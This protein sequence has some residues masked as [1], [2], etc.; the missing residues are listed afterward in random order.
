MAD[1]N[2]QL[3][4]FYRRYK[5]RDEDFEGFQDGMVDHSRGMFEGLL[6]GSVLAGLEPDPT[7][8]MFVSVSEGIA[9]GPSGYLHVVNQ[10]TLEFDTPAT[11]VRMDLVVVRPKLEENA[12]ITN[13]TNPFQQVPLRTLQGSEVLILQGDESET[14]EYPAKA[15]NDVALFGVRVE[16]AQTTLAADDLDFEARDLIGKNS[17]FQQDAAKYDDRLRPYRST[18]N[19]LGVKPSQLQPPFARVFSYVNR[20]APS[21][22][23]KDAIGNYNPE[24]TFLNF[25][26]GVITGGDESSANF[27]PTIP[28]AGN[29]IVASVG[30]D[31]DDE[32]QVR[33]GTEGTRAQCLSGVV[34]QVA[35]GAGSVLIANNVKLVAF[36]ILGSADGAAITELGFFDSRGVFGIGNDISGIQTWQSGVT[37]DE[38]NFVSDGAG[39]IYFSLV[40]S[41]VGN[42]P[43]SD[44][45]N[46]ELFSTDE[47][48][49]MKDYLGASAPRGWVLASGRT[50][51]NAS[52][53]GTER[54]NAD[55]LELFTLL[56]T[57]YSD[58]ILPIFTSAGAGSTRGANAAADFAANKRMSLPDLRGRGTIGKDDMGGS[59]ANRVTSTTV[60]P[61]GTTLGATGGAQTHTLTESELASH[62]HV[63]NS[64]NHTQD[65]HTHTQNAHVHETAF[66]DGGGAAATFGTGTNRIVGSSAA[67][68][69]APT[70][71]TQSI[72]AT[73]QNATAT[74][75]AST[76]VN[77]STGGGTAHNNLPPSFVTNKIIKL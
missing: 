18:H 34:N 76:A 74:N 21:I 10:V 45:A 35:S 67:S 51:G 42:D 8:G 59:A 38:G 26:T 1:P 16:P 13:P 58:A 63:Q 68:G 60:T 75:Q 32:I 25:E 15:A 31:T 23:P 66:F 69:S 4:N 72:A 55:T 37:Y 43:A 77:Q 29:F 47:P 73:N 53:G 61:N 64:H 7:T 20:N 40:D 28:T 6:G 54:A 65:A 71:L 46:W 48:G 44:P 49:T 33:Y 30:I 62:T 39:K 12:F 70:F 50:I 52:S 24:D 57:D 11:G 2:I 19:V 27:T 9:S 3:Y 14:P 5:W 56:W 36:V 41:N 17:F 22:F